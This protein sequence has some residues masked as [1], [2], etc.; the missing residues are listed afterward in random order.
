MAHESERVE[1]T[2]GDEASLLGPDV[3]ELDRRTGAPW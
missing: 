2:N 3:E 1:S